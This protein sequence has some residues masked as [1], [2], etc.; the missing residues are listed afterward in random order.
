MDPL[1]LGFYALICGCLS[2]FAPERLGRGP[3]FA[4]GAG[5]GI[6]AAGILPS[7]RSVLGL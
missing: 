3:R 7:L 5:V 4:I 6:L 2:S 1:S